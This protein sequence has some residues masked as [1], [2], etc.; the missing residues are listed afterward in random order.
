MEHLKQTGSVDDQAV[1]LQR[2]AS[3]RSNSTSSP[4]PSSDTARR[5]Y[6]PPSPAQ[7]P[8]QSTYIPQPSNES[9]RSPPTSPLDKP[10][11]VRFSSD[12]ARPSGAPRTFSTVELSTIDQKWGRLFD[13]DEKPTQR[14]GQ[15]LRGLANH[16]VRI[17]CVLELRVNVNWS[18]D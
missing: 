1:P 9:A 12:R 6:T 3:N 13:S 10:S 8:R 5:V 18:L 11:G 15:F 14:L 16:I 2:E 17:A 7:P 4:P